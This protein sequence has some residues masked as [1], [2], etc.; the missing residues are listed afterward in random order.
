MVHKS[1][2]QAIAICDIE[3]EFKCEK[4]FKYLCS[5]LGMFFF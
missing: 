2:D 1:Y 5:V 3:T 4:T